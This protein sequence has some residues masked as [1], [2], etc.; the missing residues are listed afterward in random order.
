MGKTERTEPC[1]RRILPK[2]V[3]G[4]LILRVHFFSHTLDVHRAHH[5]K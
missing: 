5:A 1:K 3:I 2:N 4:N